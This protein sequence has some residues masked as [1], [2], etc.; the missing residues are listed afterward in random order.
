LIEDPYKAAQIPTQFIQGSID[1]MK[2]VFEGAWNIKDRTRS[3][4]LTFVNLIGRDVVVEESYFDSGTWFQSWNPIIKT[5][6]IVQGTVANRQGSWFTGVTGGMR[7]KVQGT[8]MYI[9]LGFNNP[10]IGGYKFYAELSQT[11]R[12]AK[13]GYDHSNDNN[14]KNTQ[15]A[16]YRLQAVQTPSTI[17]QM[18]FVYEISKA[19][20]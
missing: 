10:Y 16:G 7:L 11:W 13:Y 3:L 4:Q 8:N 5:G 19:D 6:T 9:Y 14:M 2:G 12:P 1:G 18:A 20:Y 17:T 15:F